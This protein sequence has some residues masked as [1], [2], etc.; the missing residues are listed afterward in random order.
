[1]VIKQ[2]RVRKV[3]NSKIQ[4]LNDIIADID[5]LLTE[6]ETEFFRV[7]IFGSARINPGSPFYSQVEELAAALASQ[8][9]DIVTGGGPGLMEAANKGAKAGSNKSRSIGLPI[10]LPFETDANSHLDVKH[11][12]RRFSS[13]L[14]EFMRIS[15][16]VIVTPGGI[17][18]CLELFYTW[19]LMQVGHIKQRPLILLGGGMWEGLMKWLADHPLQQ[20]L[21]SRRDFDMIVV[22]DSVDDVLKALEPEI[23]KFRA[24]LPPT[25]Q[26]W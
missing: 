25:Q 9:I 5:M 21:M 1:L 26:T 18:T 6:M 19:Q 12:H 16:A 11:Q 4:Q 7:C 15:H 3:L 23:K 22:A 8:G 13:R 20:E 2:K 24:T 14:D 17:G 10:D